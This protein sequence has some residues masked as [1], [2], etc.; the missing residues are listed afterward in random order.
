MAHGIGLGNR[1]GVDE[2]DEGEH[3]R[4]DRHPQGTEP[5]I[6]E[7]S[8]NGGGSDLGEERSQQDGVEHL[9]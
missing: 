6:G 2:E 1:L 4:G 9:R 8:G 5:A 7:K 3:R